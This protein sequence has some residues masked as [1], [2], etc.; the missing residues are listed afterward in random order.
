MARIPTL[1]L[2]K[3]KNP[4]DFVIINQG[5]KEQRATY[6]ALGYTQDT[7]LDDNEATPGAKN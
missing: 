4:K 6:E 5:D 3:P 1:K 7:A 2:A